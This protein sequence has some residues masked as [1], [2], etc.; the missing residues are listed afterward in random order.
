MRIL[1]HWGVHWGPTIEGN[2]HLLVSI[3]RG[4]L[5]YTPK[6]IVLIMGRPPKRYPP[7]FWETSIHSAKLALQGTPRNEF[8]VLH[9]WG[10]GL[11]FRVSPNSTDCDRVLLA[12][13]LKPIP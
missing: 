7:S 3:N 12:S 8:K 4:T 13:A 9:G 10:L 2:L 5:V 11:G 6:V 1:I